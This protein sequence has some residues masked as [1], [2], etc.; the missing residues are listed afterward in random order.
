MADKDSRAGARYADADILDYVNR[1]HG[2]HDEAL[3]HAFRAPERGD[4]PAIQVGP[5]E[6]R[7][8]ELLLRMIGARRVVEVGTLAGYSAIR[9]A[10]ALGPDGRLWTIEMMPKHAEVARSNI[11]RAGLSDRVEVLVGEAATVLPTI[12]KHG[13]F[14]AVFVDADKE[15]YAG[16]G[17]WAARHLRAGGLLLGDNAFLF[18]GLLGDTPAAVAMRRFHEEAAAAFESVCIPTPDGLLL[19]IKR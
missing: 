17:S 14:D 13:P 2:P 18:G 12:E 9:C 19:G 10:R 4:I 7:L 6:G 8:L 11:E 5:G 1:I 15:G 16:Y 3:E